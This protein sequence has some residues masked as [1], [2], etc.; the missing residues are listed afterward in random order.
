MYHPREIRVLDRKIKMGI[1]ASEVKSHI[2]AK[3]GPAI[4]EPL[5]L[6]SRYPFFA[7]HLSQ[8]KLRPLQYYLLSITKLIKPT[9]RNPIVS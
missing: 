7:H 3:S 9:F 4:T 8:F 2:R 5:P 6:Y 1:S